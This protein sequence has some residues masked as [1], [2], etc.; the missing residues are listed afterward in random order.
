MFPMRR[1]SLP[2]L[3][4]ASSALIAQEYPVFD[5]FHVDKLFAGRA[6]PPVLRTADD[7]MFRAVIR[8]AA[9]DGP[10]FAGRYTLAQW[11]CGAGCVSVAVID[12][13]DGRIYRGPFKVLSWELL[14]YEGRY[15]SDADNFEPLAFQKD[16]RLLIARG[17]PEEKNCASYFYEWTGA[18]FKLLRRVEAAPMPNNPR[19]LAGDSAPANRSHTLD[20]LVR[21]WYAAAWIRALSCGTM[22][23]QAEIMIIQYSNGKTM[24]G[25]TLSKTASTMRVALRGHNDAIEL[26]QVNGCWITDGWEAVR[27]RPELEAREDAS[28]PTEE[29][30][31]C[32]QDLACQL[33]HSLSS[34][35]AAGLPVDAPVDTWEVAALS[36]SA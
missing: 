33:I 1:T 15:A 6:A 34:G 18:Q 10:N 4:W 23:S 19:K 24:E 11:G 28:F 30:F 16:S 26:F 22:G 17:C 9:K 35:P 3:L 14:K 12:A 2:L 32:P 31:V 7:R 8:D 27:I 29:E 20:L 36:Y 5:Q 25:V 21:K 13:A